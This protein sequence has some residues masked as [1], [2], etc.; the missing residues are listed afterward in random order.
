MNDFTFLRGISQRREGIVK[1]LVNV[2]FKWV[3]AYVAKL[4][5]RP[6]RLLD[7]V[8]PK[9]GKVLQSLVHLVGLCRR[10]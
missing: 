4:F 6:Y 3:S 5:Q 7:D 9:K 10:E 2:G 1:Y 8:L